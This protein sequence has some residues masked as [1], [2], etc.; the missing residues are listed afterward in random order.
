M[1]KTLN[2]QT[3]S[4]RISGSG[5][6]LPGLMITSNNMRKKGKALQLGPDGRAQE[7]S[8]AGRSKYNMKAQHLNP[9]RHLYLKPYILAGPPQGLG[10]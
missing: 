5:G 7:G 2:F 6:N 8:L 3:A 4:G 1:S 10:F 9:L